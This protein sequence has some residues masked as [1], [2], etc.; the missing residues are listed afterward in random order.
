MVLGVWDT[1]DQ[2]EPAT[3]QANPLPAGPEGS[4]HEEQATPRSDGVTEGKHGGPAQ[5]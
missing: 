4:F 2:P 1:G 5:L 3:C